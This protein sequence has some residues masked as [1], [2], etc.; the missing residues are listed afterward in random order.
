ML[1]QPYI[2]IQKAPWFGFAND[3]VLL[4]WLLWSSSFPKRV[5]GAVP[6]EGERAVVDG[7]LITGGGVSAGIDF[8]L[9]VV[10]TV[11]GFEQAQAIQLSIEYTYLP[12]PDS[13]LYVGPPHRAP[14]GP[15]QQ[16]RGGFEKLLKVRTETTAR[17][18]ARLLPTTATTG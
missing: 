13:R 15:T 9:F 3:L 8:A 10:G 2:P 17:A 4:L 11:L 5:L 7:N 12:P 6:V 1:E 14:Q 18:A 16:A